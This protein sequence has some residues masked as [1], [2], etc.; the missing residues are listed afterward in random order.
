MVENSGMVINPLWPFIGASPDGTIT[1]KC[2]GRGVLEIKCP[3]C[4]RGLSI[5]AAATEDN[6]FCLKKSANSTFHLDPK[7]AL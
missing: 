4:Y 2:C 7:H 5:E 1:C 3:Y 6:K